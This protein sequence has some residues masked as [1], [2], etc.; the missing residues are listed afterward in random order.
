MANI[1]SILGIMYIRFGYKVAF[2][3]SCSLKIIKINIFLGTSVSPRSVKWYS[4]NHIIIIYRSF[5]CASLSSQLHVPLSCDIAS[6]FFT[7][8][9]YPHVHLELH[10]HMKGDRLIKFGHT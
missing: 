2:F 1:V 4:E 9:F 8:V 10:G 3:T 5:C 6:S 7:R